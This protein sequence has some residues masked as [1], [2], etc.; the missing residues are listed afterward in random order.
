MCMISKVSIRKIVIMLSVLLSL[1][2][3]ALPGFGWCM[4]TEGTNQSI[5]IPMSQWNLLK[6]ELMQLNQELVN[7][8]TELQKLKK[9]S[10]KLMSQLQKAEEMLNQSQTEL[11]ESRTILT[12]LYNEVDELRTL[13]TKLKEQIDKERRTHKRQIWQNRIW[14]L[15]IGCGIGYAINR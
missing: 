4:T 14:F 15:V 12:K 2:L 1:Q 11:A 5:T 9:P 6:S 3:Y 13:L 10:A 8:Q 7:C